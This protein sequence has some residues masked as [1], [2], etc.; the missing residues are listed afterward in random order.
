M[1]AHI[2]Y[3]AVV[4]TAVPEDGKKKSDTT[5]KKKSAGDSLGVVSFVFIFFSIEFIYYQISTIFD[6][7]IWYLKL[8]II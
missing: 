7:F 2:V 3:T 6:E 8:F 4:G 5:S 1:T